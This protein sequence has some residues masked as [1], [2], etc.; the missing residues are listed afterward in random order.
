MA[1]TIPTQF[2]LMNRD[3]KVTPAT[4]GEQKVMEDYDGEGGSLL[5]LCDYEHERIVLAKHRTRQSLEHTFFHELSHAMF[6]A[7]GRPDLSE[8][9]ALVDA[10]GAALHQYHK[11]KKGRLTLNGKK[12]EGSPAGR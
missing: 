10:L 4:T 6:E 2:S 7:V 9:E 8:D 12:T 5:G 1:V 3:Y 11:T